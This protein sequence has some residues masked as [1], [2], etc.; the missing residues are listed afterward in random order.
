MKVLEIKQSDPFK[1]KQGLSNYPQVLRLDAI[2]HRYL[3]LYPKNKSFHT[4]SETPSN[5]RVSLGYIKKDRDHSLKFNSLL[6]LHCIF[7]G[8][9]VIILSYITDIIPHLLEFQISL[10][11]NR[12][13]ALS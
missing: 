9:D 11:G 12:P 6:A 8:C 5:A 10:V 13:Y 2:K 1:K 3:S 7:F 4:A